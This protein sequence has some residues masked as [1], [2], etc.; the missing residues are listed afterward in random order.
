MS[1][2][3]KYEITVTGCDDETVVSMEL[4]AQEHDLIDHL[5]DLISTRSAAEEWEK[6]SRHNGS[7]QGRIVRRYVTP[8]EEA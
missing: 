5:A 8:M 6:E 1:D 3:R 7:E 4:T 2:T